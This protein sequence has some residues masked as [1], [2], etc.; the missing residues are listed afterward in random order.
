MNIWWDCFL[1]TYFTRTSFCLQN[2]NVRTLQNDFMFVCLEKPMSMSINKIST[3]QNMFIYGELYEM[4]QLGKR[5]KGGKDLWR[6]LIISE[7]EQGRIWTITISLVNWLLD[8]KGRLL[9][10]PPKMYTEERGYIQFIL[11]AE[12]W[13]LWF[14]AICEERVYNMLWL[15]IWVLLCRCMF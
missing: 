2:Y 12:L 1:K 8:V 4:K 7:R 6:N 10:S 13:L 15:A 9:R 3:R 14:L 11:S 5:A